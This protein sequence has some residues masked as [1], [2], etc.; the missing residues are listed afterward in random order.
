MTIPKDYNEFIN[1][2]GTFEVT[3]SSYYKYSFTFKCKCDDRV[4]LI[5]C[6]GSSDDIYKLEI[7]NE[8]M[9]ISDIEPNWAQWSDDSKSFT[10]WRW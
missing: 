7:T 5:G 8:P 6:G 1:D 9:K 10:D 3:F 4:L 2:F